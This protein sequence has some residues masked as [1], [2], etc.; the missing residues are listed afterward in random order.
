MSQPLEL[1]S[2]E[3]VS[4][5]EKWQRR[6]VAEKSIWEEVLDKREMQ[7]AIPFI[8]SDS[9]VNN[10]PSRNPNLDEV[11]SLNTTLDLLWNPG[12]FF[13]A[14]NYDGRDSS[15]IREH[16]QKIMVNKPDVKLIVLV[17]DTLI[18]E[19]E[20]IP[21]ENDS[22]TVDD[23][24]PKLFADQ[25]EYQHWL[26]IFNQHRMELESLAAKIGRSNSS[27]ETLQ[28]LAVTLHFGL[29][30]EKKIPN[31]G[32]ETFENKIYEKLDFDGPH[33]V[34]LIHHPSSE[35]ELPHN[36]QEIVFRPGQTGEVLHLTS[37]QQGNQEK[38]KFGSNETVVIFP[39]PVD[40]EE[41][42]PVSFDLAL[43]PHT[44]QLTTLNTQ[45][46]SITFRTE[47]GTSYNFRGREPKKNRDLI[48]ATN[49]NGVG[50]VYLETTPLSEV[51]FE[52]GDSIIIE[53]PN[54]KET[55][56]LT[57][58]INFE[59]DTVKISPSQEIH[60]PPKTPLPEEESSR[61]FLERRDRLPQYLL[62]QRQG[63]F[64]H[65]FKKR[66]QDSYHKLEENPETASLIAKSLAE[67]ER[68]LQGGTDPIQDIRLDYSLFDWLEKAQPFFAASQGDDAEK[69][70]NL[71]KR[72]N[73]G[74]EEKW[75][76][77][78][79]IHGSEIDHFYDLVRQKLPPE[80]QASFPELTPARRLL[81]ILT[82]RLGQQFDAHY[83][84]WEA[85]PTA[86]EAYPTQY[87]NRQTLGRD[88]L[89]SELDKASARHVWL[90][91]LGLDLSRWRQILTEQNRPPQSLRPLT[92]AVLVQNSFDAKIE[93][94]LADP[95]YDT[96]SGSEDVKARQQFIRESFQ[97]TWNE[98]Q[99]LGKT[100]SDPQRYQEQTVDLYFRDLINR[101][102][103]TD[104]LTWYKE[105]FLQHYREPADASNI[106]HDYTSRLFP[107]RNAYLIWV[108]AFN[109]SQHQKDL[110]LLAERW[111]LP[112]NQSSL[113]ILALMLRLG[114]E[115]ESPLWQL[116]SKPKPNEPK[117][118]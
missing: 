84:G 4:P 65:Q 38:T 14:A 90:E 60:L 80:Q 69:I 94:T 30:R 37:Y 39:W 3:L 28:W 34:T 59:N 106:P 82:L 78:I 103:D 25:K 71:V 98:L 50:G 64:G 70:L 6:L 96:V 102:P 75:L 77:Q 89:V 16:I 97:N 110:K 86:V 41:D 33:P 55:R 107:D 22:P 81:L 99:Q 66:L 88:K 51:V 48:F 73:L 87:Q 79:E 17:L 114:V 67:A 58:K 27:K 44:R 42:W 93:Q 31:V 113:K 40:P 43:D 76:R 74:W 13:D 116:P 109:S 2:L 91:N 54:G 15:A 72:D 8:T 63:E 35:T 7:L 32:S 83:W 61:A 118:P 115:G 56:I 36:S 19:I 53:L 92:D 23:I 52:D 21:K 29:E 49:K 9:E 62:I 111:G 45:N 20:L 57:L 112:T 46:A 11:R 26:E 104:L 100:A 95:R 117:Q 85:Q 5:R 10:L 105:A 1:S 108:R 12:M 47:D 68:L 18:K 101:H 24:F